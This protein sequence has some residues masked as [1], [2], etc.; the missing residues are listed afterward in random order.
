M[1]PNDP[2]NDPINDPV[3]DPI[4]DP[5]NEPLTPRPRGHRRYWGYYNRPYPGC[6]CLWIL[7]ILFI[8]WWIAS[9]GYGGGRGGWAW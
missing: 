9:W 8:I 5:L 7:I 4:N 3:A 2:R 1:D 6:G